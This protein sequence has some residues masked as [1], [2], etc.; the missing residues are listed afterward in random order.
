[1]PP[2]LAAAAAAA[3]SAGGA[4]ASG[5]GSLGSALG[6]GGTGALT[7]TSLGATTAAGTTPGLALGTASPLALGAPG[8]ALAGTTGGS[9]FG[10]G[11]GLTGTG[12]GTTGSLA[13]GA[14][15][16]A[17][18]VPATAAKSGLSGLFESGLA[19]GKEFANTPQGGAMLSSLM[20]PKQAPPASPGSVNPNLGRSQ[21]ANPDDQIAMILQRLFGTDIGVG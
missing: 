5:L 18:A 3:S 8:G 11:S 2:A 15:G 1:M 13:A 19:K 21:Q 16:G 10:A 7:G 12:L 20:A 9:L 17:M 6:L 14:P 4:I